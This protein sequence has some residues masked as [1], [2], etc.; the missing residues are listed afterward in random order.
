MIIKIKLDT[1]SNIKR[2]YFFLILLECNIFNIFNL[3]PYFEVKTNRYLVSIISVILCIWFLINTRLYNVIKSCTKF[4]NI[5]CIILVITLFIHAIYGIYQYNQTAFDMFI[6]EQ[7]FLNIF[8][9]YP[10]LYLFIT[11]ISIEKVLSI[12]SRLAF[13]GICILTIQAILFNEFGIWFMKGLARNFRDG[14]VRIEII[15]LSSVATIY[16]FFKLLV[17]PI[18]LKYIIIT[19]I[20]IFFL[21]YVYMTRMY[22]IS[23]FTTLLIMIILKKKR[24]SKKILVFLGLLIVTVTLYNL[25]VFENLKNTFSSTGEKANSTIVR[26][27]AIKY[28]SQY[29]DNNILLGMG[30]VRPYRPDLVDIWSGPSHA[31]FFDDIG[32]LG[33]FFRT[34]LSSFAIY[35]LLL[36]R[37]IYI[38][39]KLI[40]HKL[41]NEYLL[42]SGIMAYLIITSA[43]L[44]ITDGQRIFALPIYV[45][46]FEYCNYKHNNYIK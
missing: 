35:F 22:T 31:Y 41:G 29:T 13:F 24:F 3:L 27:E 30:F 18:K 19:S 10:L 40:L 6:E 33:L 39:I 1:N 16:Y 28:F 46:I 14:R 45:A 11:D 15:S 43:T 21:L 8:L 38:T 7:S 26:L 4:L 20:N 2:I 44:L 23:I 5:Y 42:C 25:G 17:K 37:M 34:G 9:A 12:V 36:I 32:A